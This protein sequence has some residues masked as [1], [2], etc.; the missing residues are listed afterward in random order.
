[1]SGDAAGMSARFP[2]WTRWSVVVI[3]CAS[4]SA[5]AFA[6]GLIAKHHAAPPAE[7]IDGP[8]RLP[9]PK[10][11]GV[12]SRSA[13]I[14][15]TLAPD[16]RG[17][18]AWEGAIPIDD[19]RGVRLMAL[20]ADGADWAMEVMPPGGEAISLAPNM[21]RAGVTPTTGPVA[22]DAMRTEAT[23]YLINGERAG[24]WSVRIRRDAARGGAREGVLLVTS[25]SETRL[26]ARLSTYELVAGRE[27]GVTATLDGNGDGVMRVARLRLRG[28]DGEARTLPMFDDGRHQDGAAGDG[29]FGATFVVAPG[30]FTAEVE[31]R[32]RVRDGAPVLRTAAL[33][34][35]VEEQ[36]IE[37][38]DA[39][40]AS[41]NDV[42][43]VTV[44][45]PVAADARGAVKV[46]AEV[47]AIGDAGEAAPL[48]WLGAM[49]EVRATEAGPALALSM[50][51]A[52]LRGAE[53][54]VAFELRNVRAHS[55]ET[56]VIVG[57]ATSMPIEIGDDVRRLAAARGDAAPRLIAPMR[58][59][60]RIASTVEIDAGVER[61]F[62]AHNLMLVHGYCSGGVW[63][64]SN[65]SGFLEVFLDA[66]Q[67]RSHDQFAQLMLAFGNNSKS[68]GV[69]AHSQ[70]G[71]AALHLWTNYFSGL[72]WA[73][74]PRLI[75]SVGTPYQGTPLAGNLAV[76]GEIFGSGCGVNTDLST[77][78]A[79][80]WLSTIPTASRSA[81]HY[82][83]TSFLDDGGFDYCNLLTDF[84]LS[85]PDDGVIER[86][87]GQLS[88]ANNRGH[89]EGWCHTM[90]MRDPAQYTDS[91]R[92]AEMNANA[93]R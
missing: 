32:G 73:E 5:A 51:P 53:D 3:G 57:S 13:V 25:E 71:S 18:L 26:E 2:K 89:V 33:V 40:I 88:G 66:N 92:N 67:N 83:T 63:P 70:G 35:A 64:T 36:G 77:D 41:V 61:A 46:C 48:C 56:H 10:A 93:A 52:W 47:W 49:A 69:V 42:E 15:V 23:R 21:R 79:A 28:A 82:Y 60:H 76:L 55:R 90:G 39:A 85:D 17:G 22:I 84:F 27:I 7:F 37:F 6:Q 8:L 58:E 4:L 20:G 16:G 81:V 72:D 11:H 87:R 38:G 68:F 29:V 62:G 34:F 24:N 30:T 19:P 14:R 86:A 44:R 9:D 1:M 54:A 31:A 74:G 59:E 65:F 43:F 91:G 80:V 12:D 45:L 75:Q 50:D 78:G